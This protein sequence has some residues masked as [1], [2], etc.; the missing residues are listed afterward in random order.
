MNKFF[1]YRFFILF[2]CVFQYNYAQNTF[3]LGS[4]A[5]SSFGST[6]LTDR[7]TDQ[8]NNVNNLFDFSVY[9]GNEFIIN[10]YLKIIS[11]IFYLNNNLTLATNGNKVF[12]LHQNIGFSL[13]PAYY[14]NRHTV[15]IS[16]GILAVYVFD[17]DELLGNQLDRFDEAYFWGLGYGLD[18]A[19]NIFMNLEFITSKF[20]SISHWTN[21]TLE[22]FSVLQVK[23]CYKIN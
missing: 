3:Y 11:E 23:F 21:Y 15:F 1:L 7:D 18:I 5:I 9:Y 16:S 6:I 2:L 10:S 13:K 19:N 4:G 8:N 20:E 14:I 12:E 22:S 17:K